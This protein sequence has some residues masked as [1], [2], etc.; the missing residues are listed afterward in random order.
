MND[1]GDGK[2]HFQINHHP[3]LTNPEDSNYQHQQNDRPHN[4]E[5][6]AEAKWT[7]NIPR[8]ARPGLLKSIKLTLHDQYPVMAIIEMSP[9]QNF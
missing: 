4:D 3:I 8:G 6:L 5:T 2:F 9:Y 1:V 7:I